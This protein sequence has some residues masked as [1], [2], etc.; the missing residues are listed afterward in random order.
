LVGPSGSGKTELICRLLAYWQSRDLRVAVV[1]HSH[2]QPALD[3]PGKDTWR[4]R[5]C[6]A[7]AVALVTPRVGQIIQTWEDEPPLLSILESLP[8][9]LDLI[10][11]EGYKT[12]PLPKLVIVPLEC[13]LDEL[14]AYPQILGYISDQSLD[15]DLPVWRRD[16]ITDIADFIQAI[17]NGR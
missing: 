3:Q 10:L 4:F 9:P 1:K 7:R 8:P 14:Q 5:Q 11:V 6:G 17:G 12:G 2:K 13:S 15:T 16:Q